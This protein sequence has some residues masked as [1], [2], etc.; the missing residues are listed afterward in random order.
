M[1]LRDESIELER[2]RVAKLTERANRAPVFALSLDSLNDLR[3]NGLTLGVRGLHM[4]LTRLFRALSSG[5]KGNM[6]VVFSE[7][8]AME[9]STSVLISKAGFGATLFTDDRA[10]RGVGFAAILDAGLV[11]DLEIRGCLTLFEN[12][13]E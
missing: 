11:A 6:K 3:E 4:L 5:V 7:I 10:G 8:F 12:F 9:P 2:E 1:L 13:G